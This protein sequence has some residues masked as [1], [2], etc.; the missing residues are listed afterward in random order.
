MAAGARATRPTLGAEPHVRLFEPLLTHTCRPLLRCGLITG[1]GSAG[2]NRCSATAWVT[3]MRLIAF[4]V[5]NRTI[6]SIAALVNSSRR[7]RH[8]APAAHS[9]VLGDPPNGASPIRPEIISGAS[10]PQPT[11]RLVIRGG[12]GMVRIPL[13]RPPSFTKQRRATSWRGH[14]GRGGATIAEQRKRTYRRRRGG[15][16]RSPPTYSLPRG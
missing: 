13:L 16:N 9:W 14:W 8:R 15:N 3:P 6:H 1:G 4:T 11:W 2:H 12:M 10:S 7:P 5:S